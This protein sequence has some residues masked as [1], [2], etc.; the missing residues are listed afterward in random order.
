MLINTDF[1]VCNIKYYIK[2]Y[3][4]ETEINK[5]NECIILSMSRYLIFF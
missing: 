3:E 1:N 4:K 5:N 2:Y